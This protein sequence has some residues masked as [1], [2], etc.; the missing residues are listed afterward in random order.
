MLVECI[1][2]V[3]RWL[4]YGAILI[5]DCIIGFDAFTFS[6]VVMI[7][8]HHC[9]MH[10]CASGKSGC[11]VCRC[12]FPRKEGSWYLRIPRNDQLCCS[13]EDHILLAKVGSIDWRLC[14]N[15]WAV[16]QYISK[17]ATKAQQGSRRM[18]EVLS[19]AVDDVCRFVSREQDI[20]RRCIRSLF[21]RSLGERDYHVY[22]AVHVGLGF[23]YVFPLL[24][25]VS[26]NT[27]GGARF[28][29]TSDT[30]RFRLG[31]YDGILV[32]HDAAGLWFLRI[33]RNDELCF[34][35]AGAFL[36]A[37]LG[38]NDLLPCLNLCAVVQYMCHYV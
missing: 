33:T 12:G 11:A 17:Y 8:V 26:L 27:S 35:Y 24:L 25:A 4:H 3:Q 37:N 13:Y 31:G 30:L 36:L 21:V 2:S 10:P 20:L 16:L 15:L 29:V 5:S 18:P 34:S 6:V 14:L 1:D 28:E 9:A 7:R 23:P 38:N 19:G 32:K 22:E